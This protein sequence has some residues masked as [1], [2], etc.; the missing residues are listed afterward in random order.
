LSSTPQKGRR[1]FFAIF[2]VL[3][4]GTLLLVKP[5]LAV[6][7]LSLVTVLILRPLYAWIGGR[8]RLEGHTSLAV[9]LTML[10]AIIIIFVPLIL[11]AILIINQAADLLET[12]KSVDGALYIETV[13]TELESVV[14]SVP[15]LS[16]VQIDEQQVTDF[17]TTQIIAILGWLAGLLKGLIGSLPSLFIN[18]IIFLVMVASLLPAWDNLVIAIEELNPLDIS[19]SDLYVHKAVTMSM[20]MFRGVFV[21]AVVQSLI[22]GLIFWVAGIEFAAFLALICFFL[23]IVPALG[24]SFVALPAAVIL[25]LMGEPSSAL[26]VLIGFYGVVTPLN[27]VL[28]PRPDHKE[29]YFHFA[30]V[31][32]SI[33][34]GILLFGLVGAIYGPVIMILMITSVNIHMEYFSRS[35]EEKGRAL[36][37][38]AE[39]NQTG[40]VDGDPATVAEDGR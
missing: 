5:F 14:R 40:S 12:V 26:L 7:A 6:I 4:L 1:F 28:R 20:A 19:L 22:M 36:A 16:D 13:V 11:L 8:R 33:F 18:G 34:G 15:I 10:I 31:F 29:V 3:A 17:L 38:T 39:A 24:I 37:S 23:A 9:T 25:L 21:V 2:A 30:L 32:I 27:R 35:A